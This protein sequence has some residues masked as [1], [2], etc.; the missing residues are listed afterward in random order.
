V[1]AL[2]VAGEGFVSLMVLRMRRVV[3]VAAAR[4]GVARE[5]EDREAALPRIASLVWTRLSRRR[6][7]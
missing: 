1:V 7:I 3:A 6:L 5:S 4:R 2:F